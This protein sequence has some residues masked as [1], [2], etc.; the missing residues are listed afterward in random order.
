MLAPSF[1]VAA[2]QQQQKRPIPAG[3]DELG[4]EAHRLVVARKRLVEPALV[5]LCDAEIIVGRCVLRVTGQG[6]FEASSRLRQITLH[7]RK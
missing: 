4:V 5:V 7:L 1:G 2:H 3:I 6:P